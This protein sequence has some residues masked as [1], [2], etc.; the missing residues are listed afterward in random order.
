MRSNQRAVAFALFAF[1]NLLW[2]GNWSTGRA[3][4]GAFD[5]VM[6]NFVRWLVA[7]AALAPFALPRLAGMGRVIRGDARML[8]LLAATDVALFQSIVYLGLRTTTAVN[9]VLLN[10]AAPL[11]FLLCSWAIERERPRPRQIA[12]MAISLAGILVILARGEPR[13]L[14]DLRFHA[15]VGPALGAAQAPAAGAGRHRVPVRDRGARRCHA[16]AGRSAARARGAAAR[17]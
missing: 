5:P 1:A 15:G 4:R 14:L 8:A 10:C 7:L 2:A 3:L 6:L 9:A 17:A 11:V 16:R 12:G 13:R